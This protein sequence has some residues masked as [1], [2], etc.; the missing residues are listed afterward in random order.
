MQG[1]GQ[2][3]NASLP[4]AQTQSPSASRLRATSAGL[5]QAAADDDDDAADRAVYLETA[6]RNVGDE[7]SRISSSSSCSSSGSDMRA[8]QSVSEVMLR[9]PASES[10]MV[11]LEL[12]SPL[13]DTSS[14]GDQAY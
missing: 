7:Q 13:C 8:Q 3:S 4:A 14:E 9:P 10:M 6:R 11:P 5:C 1:S 2:D 12:P